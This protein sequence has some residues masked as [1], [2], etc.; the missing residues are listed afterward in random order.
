VKFAVRLARVWMN[1]SCVC[2]IAHSLKY[3]V[4]AAKL[5][6]EVGAESLPVRMCVLLARVL[7]VTSLKLPVDGDPWKLQL[8]G[9]GC[10]P[11]RV[12]R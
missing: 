7:R 6:G 10:V 9:E 12:A 3:F 2:C 11:R 1:A 4:F 5:V 8:C